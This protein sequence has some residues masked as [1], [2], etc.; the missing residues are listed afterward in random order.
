MELVR[1]VYCVAGRSG[2][3]RRSRWTRL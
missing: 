3:D 2:P 1:F